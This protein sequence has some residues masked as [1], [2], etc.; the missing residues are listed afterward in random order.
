MAPFIRSLTPVLCHILYLQAEKMGADSPELLALENLF[1]GE[2]ESSLHCSKCPY[3]SSRSE[4]FTYALYS[5]L[6]Q[7]EHHFMKCH[8]LII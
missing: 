4:E 2:L 1:K 3:T 6:C 5:S 7:L 8:H